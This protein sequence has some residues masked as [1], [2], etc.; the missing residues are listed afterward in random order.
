MLAR[1]FPER[2][3]HTDVAFWLAFKVRKT[4]PEGIEGLFDA[5]D[6]SKD[7][8]VREK[9]AASIGR[10]FRANGLD[11]GKNKKT[12]DACRSWYSENKGRIEPSIKYGDNVMHL[13]KAYARQG[14]FASKAAGQPASESGRGDTSKAPRTTNTE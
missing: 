14:L 12:V 9:I 13:Q 7:P 1:Y 2:M 10:A 4:L 6:R 3:Y 8:E 11:F 5:F